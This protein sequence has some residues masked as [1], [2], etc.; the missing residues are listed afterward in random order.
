VPEAADDNGSEIMFDASADPI[1]ESLYGVAEGMSG[2]PL[3][4]HDPANDTDE[5]VGAVAYG[6]E[7]DASGMGLATPI[8]HMMTL[9]AQAAPAPDAVT[10]TVTLKRP[11]TVAGAKVDTIVVAPTDAAARAVKVGSHTLVA[12]PLATLAVTGIPAASPL[13]TMLD[14][15]LT[16]KGIQ[17]RAGL[18]GG[19]AGTEPDFTTA[20]D[21]GSAVGEFFGWGDYSYGG[22]G[23]TTYTTDDGKL[24]AFGHPML[25]DGQV[26]AFLTNSDTIGLWSNL[27]TPMKM[28]A[29]GKIR[30]AVTVDSGPGIA[31][32]VDDDAIP[33]E[34]P[35]IST[36]TNDATGAT[37]SSTTYVTPFA[38]A[39]LK[40]PFPELNASA[41]YPAMFQA[42]GDEYYDGHVSY[43]LKIEVNNG[44]TS[45]E[46]VR[47]NQ[48]EDTTGW[49]AA[50]FAVS[51]IYTILNQLNTDPDGT[52][53]AHVT[54]I[55]LVSHLSPQ[56]QR[57]RIAGATV[58]RGLKIGA[59]TVHVSFYP[60]GSATPVTHDVTLTI[61]K[62]TSLGGSLYVVSPD[63]G[64]ENFGGGGFFE[65]M[66]S[67]GPTGPPT[68]L[69]DVVAQIR[70]QYAN[71]DC[72]VVYDPVQG[73]GDIGDYGGGYMPWSSKATVPTA[74]DEHEFL[75]GGV[76]KDCAD[77]R[78]S[79]FPHP[80]TAGE[81]LMAGGELDA[82]TMDGSTGTDIA[83]STVALYERTAGQATDRLV[84]TVPLQAADRG[85]DDGP[86]VYMYQTV[87]PPVN[88]NVTV[89]AVWNGDAQYLSA[90]D[91]VK[92][93]VAPRVGL[94]VTRK[95]DG[96]L[97]LKATIAPA[98]SGV[99]AFARVLPHGRLSLIKAV[100]LSHG[101][102]HASWKAPA[103]T[104][105]LRAIFRGNALNGAGSS[106]TIKVTMP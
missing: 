17:L 85:S 18:D 14:K 77:L 83:G 41:F 55:T 20:F 79:V 87:L 36:A 88:H 2:S 58:D 31:G 91:S 90:S 43:E 64:Y 46:I 72:L 8:E 21:P 25:F 74:T 65:E 42:V 97:L 48:W 66:E 50:F 75:T 29:T 61:P 23:T 62:G 27:D 13:F 92:V 28:F 86:P 19:S 5:L 70:S 7:L 93:T 80:G 56:H 9:E 89:T 95:P 45:Y 35:L 103:G 96:V 16:A 104:Y 34:V 52:I 4:V 38:I 40:D 49:D 1:I 81:P 6:F 106:R 67:S 68:T 98:S 37:V 59:N 82:Q 26:S 12:H 24:V 78:L 102:A 22:T 57:A 51:D 44:T 69:A 71:N 10:R 94:S 47:D 11:L 32:L 100:K 39:E 84:A 73:Y 101:R 3:Y 54:A 30:G 15:V 105:K 60:Y 99:I 33:T 76:E 63:L 53:H